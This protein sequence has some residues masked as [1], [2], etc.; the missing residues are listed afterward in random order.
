L[1]TTIFGWVF[2]ASAEPAPP[3]GPERPSPP[4]EPRRER[5]PGNFQRPGPQDPSLSEDQRTALRETMEASRKEAGP[6]EEKMR[7]A[8]RELQEAIHAEKVDEPAIREKAA[9]VGKLEGDLAV[10]RAKAF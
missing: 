5:P 2:T 6:L 8:R 7:A 10:I 9:A 1:A 3:G 4:A